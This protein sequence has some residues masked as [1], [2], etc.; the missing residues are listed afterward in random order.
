ML[1]KNLWILDRKELFS[2]IFLDLIILIIPFYK[3]IY[4]TTDSGQSIFSLVFVGTWIIVNYI[5]GRYHFKQKSNISYIK[6]FFKVFFSSFL[7]VLFC[8]L[9]SFLNFFKIDISEL[10][11]LFLE[12]SILSF[13][14][15]ILFYKLLINRSIKNF[16]VWFF[17]GNNKRLNTIR[18]YTYNDKSI[19]LT[20]SLNELKYLMG[21][22]C[23][24]FKGIIFDEV[25]NQELNFDSLKL[26]NNAPIKKISASKWCESYFYKLPTEFIKNTDLKYNYEYYNFQ[27]RLKNISDIILSTI[28][29]IITIPIFLLVIV[30]IKLEDGGT[31]FYSQE[32]I[33]K[34]GLIFKILKFRSMKIDAEKNGPVWSKRGDK[35]ITNIGKLLRISRIDELPQLFCVLKGEMSLI[36]PRPER[37]EIEKTL[38]KEIPYYSYRRALKP[39]LSGWAQ[40][41]YP[42][43]ASLEDAK[44]KTSYDIFYIENFSNILDII[45]FFKTIKLVF[46]LKG[47]VPKKQI[48]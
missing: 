46:N 10:L 31:V 13:V 8:I 23:N 16:N 6:Y 44:E 41:N 36:G 26:K 12:K 11:I 29:L 21:D 42:Y 39:G 32:R 37:P 30:L 28:L 20:N 24:N 40:V 22:S 33:G 19:I 38:E 7:L 35:R 27:T 18:K 17:N 47:A 1:N 5:F 34:N 25:S 43:G 2:R 15:Q 3:E 14:I 9:I 48:D 45:I 4:L